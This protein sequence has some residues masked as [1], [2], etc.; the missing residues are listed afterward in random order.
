MVFAFGCAA[1]FG[2]LD[3]PAAQQ[4]EQTQ[5]DQS[6]P[7]TAPEESGLALDESSY[8]LADEETA[9]AEQSSSAAGS[10]FRAIFALAVVIGLIYAFIFFLRKASG[11]QTA[12]SPFI[13]VLDAA[14]LKGQTGLYIVEAAGKVLLLGAGDNVSLLSEINNQEIIDEIKLKASQKPA[15]LGFAQMLQEKLLKKGMAFAQKPDQS[16]IIKSQTDRLKKL[17]SQQEDKGE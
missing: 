4:A 6:A 2:A 15:V 1:V 11:R 12:E 17:N 13:K 3:E 16:A 14:S 5:T 9:A 10:F 8:V 7:E